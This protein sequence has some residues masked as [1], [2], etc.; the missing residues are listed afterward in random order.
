M[1]FKIHILA[2]S[3]SGYCYRFLFDKSEKEDNKSL[4]I[5][6]SLT[7]NITS[8]QTLYMD[9]WYSS[10]DGAI[11]LSEKGI[12]LTGAINLNCKGLNGYFTEVA[13]NISLITD[14]VGF[15]VFQF[16]DEKKT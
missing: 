15:N 5:I 7:D 14:N 2:A 16:N 9:S 12:N 8:G 13:A 1:G 10:P 3:Q 4:K 6:K 11:H